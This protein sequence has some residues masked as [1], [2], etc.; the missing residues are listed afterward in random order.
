MDYYEILQVHPKADADAIAAS[1]TR[2]R[3]RYEPARLEGA[4]EELVD[5][6]R[7]R[8]DDIERAYAVLS[9]PVRRA[10]YDE[11]QRAIKPVPL[12]SI[13]LPP[14]ATIDQ[15]SALANGGAVSAIDYSPLP[16]AQRQERAKSF[17]AQPLTSANNV[18]TATARSPGRVARAQKARPFWIVPLGVLAALMTIVVVT[19]LVATSYGKGDSDVR[20]SA[21]PAASG[22]AQAAANPASAQ[23]TPSLDEIIN[24]YEPMIAGAQQTVK[25]SAGDADA[26]INLGNLLFDSAQVV[27]ENEPN[28]DRYQQ[29]LPRWLEASEAY[30]KALAITPNNAAVRADMAASLCYY[31]DG[32]SDQNYVSRGI[33]EAQRAAQQGPQEPRV[34]FNLAICQ[35]THQPPQIADAVK[36]WQQVAGMS[37]KDPALATQ[38]QRLI[39]QYQQ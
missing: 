6:A 28:S 11:E 8:R 30:T 35:V 10:S 22:T 1:Y 3:E 14:G 31:G 24:Q 33:T 38:A 27:R 19:S 36:N 4:A 39:A 9:D 7:R 16:P 17:D 13:P 20:T 21:Q 37:A 23:P 29:R 26:W 32:K 5:L 2:L 18:R 15:V 34:L 25:T 12:E